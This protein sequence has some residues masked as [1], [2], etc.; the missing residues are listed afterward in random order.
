MSACMHIALDVWWQLRIALSHK[1]FPRI[2]FCSCPSMEF[3]FSP[4]VQITRVEISSK[5]IVF[6]SRVNRFNFQCPNDLQNLDVSNRCWCSVASVVQYFDYF[7]SILI[8]RNLPNLPCLCADTKMS[9][10]MMKSCWI[11]QNARNELNFDRIISKF[12]SFFARGVFFQ[13]IFR[14]KL[15]MSNLEHANGKSFKLMRRFFSVARFRNLYI[16]FIQFFG[17][18]GNFNWSWRQNC[19]GTVIMNYETVFY[20]INCSTWATIKWTNNIYI[21]MQP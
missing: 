12:S 5:Q 19:K 8:F 17:F 6:E 15:C 16:F 10:L 11:F 4:K 20:A 7:R 3:R 13:N 21:A 1:R 9:S 14:Q 2:V 18:D